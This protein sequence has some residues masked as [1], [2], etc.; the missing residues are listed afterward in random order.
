VG[1]FHGESEADGFVFEKLGEGRW[2]VN[3]TTRV[4]DFQREYPAL[5]PIAGVETMGGLVMAL[6]DVVPAPGQSA[7]YGGVR[8]TAQA[9][10]ERRVREVLVENLRRKGGPDVGV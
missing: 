10:D 2:R 3:G 7:V 4:E 5:Q 6:L 9:T 1:T 8:L